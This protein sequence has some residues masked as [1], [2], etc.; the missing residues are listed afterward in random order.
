MRYFKSLKF[1]KSNKVGM[2]KV[3]LNRELDGTEHNYNII[4][5]PSKS[6]GYGLA[7]Y[8][9]M[10]SLEAKDILVYRRNYPSLKEA[11]VASCQVINE[12]EKEDLTSYI[13]EWKS[14]NIRPVFDEKYEYMGDVYTTIPILK[15]DSKSFDYYNNSPISRFY[16]NFYILDRIGGKNC[17]KE[18]AM[19]FGTFTSKI[20]SDKRVIRKFLSQLSKEKYCR[21]FE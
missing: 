1:L 19:N 8:L 17:Y 6:G 15:E 21:F 7:V 14:C 20:H 11:E 2:F 10:T 9:A 18:E 16:G 13:E 3:S 4:A 5:Y 12:L